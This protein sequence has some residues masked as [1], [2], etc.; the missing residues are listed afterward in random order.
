MDTLEEAGL[1]KYL[2]EMANIRN[3]NSWM[4]FH[5]PEKAV[6][7]AKDLIR[8][9]VARVTTLGPLHDKQISIIDKALVIGGGVAGMT[10]A[11]AL[12]DQGFH[13][14]LVEKTDELGGMGKKLIHTIEGDNIQSFVGELTEQVEA[15][16]HIDVLKQGIITDFGGYK[17]NFSTQ[18]LVGGQETRKIDH[19]VMIVAT[20]AVEYQPTEFLYP[21]NDAVVTQVELA[22]LLDQGKI[23]SPDRVVMIQ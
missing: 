16:E 20:G 15:H 6:E 21:D 14:T 1:N 3:Q 8:M 23:K 13:V 17:G 19:G 5:E 4:H 18:V 2:F 10:A 12:G 11:K 9:A 22:T 7:K